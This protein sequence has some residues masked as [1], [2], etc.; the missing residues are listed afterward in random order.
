MPW[1]PT[2]QKTAL[3]KKELDQLQ[4]CLT[5]TNTLVN[6]VEETH[7]DVRH[8]QQYS[9][10]ALF[11]L[12]KMSLEM[13]QLNGKLHLLHAIC[14][15]GEPALHE[16]AESV[17][18]TGSYQHP[19]PHLTTLTFC[20]LLTNSSQTAQRACDV[21]IELA[22][23]SQTVDF[24][25]C[26]R[27]LH[28]GREYPQ[29]YDYFRARLKRAFTKNRDVVEPDQIELLLSHGQFVV[30]ELEALYMLRKYRTLKK[31]YYHDS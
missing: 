25:L 30:K 13:S 31:R 3:T 14:V 8:K 7:M 2:A 26:A 17:E 27:L 10:H 16:I 6:E 19:H 18:A 24:G 12:Q 9:Y 22:N 11:Q 15:K 21:D 20:K 23:C 29:G 5:S 4:E 1:Y 28:L